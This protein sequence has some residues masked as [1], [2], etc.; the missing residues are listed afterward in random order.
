MNKLNFE[1]ERGIVDILAEN[2][3]YIAMALGAAMAGL[4][5]VL[6]KGRGA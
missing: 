2:L 3:S 6:S 4:G 5:A 1:E